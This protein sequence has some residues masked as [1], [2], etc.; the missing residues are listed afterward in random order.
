MGHF[1]RWREYRRRIAVFLWAGML[2]FTGVLAGGCGAEDGAKML[3][4]TGI[5]SW[6]ETLPEK[7]EEQKQLQETAELLEIERV[8]QAFPESMEEGSAGGFIS[9]LG[10]R[11][12]ECYGLIGTPEWGTDS[13]M[14]EACRRID[15]LADYN[16]R[17]SDG[18]R[19]AGV[20]ADIEPYLLSRWDTQPRQVMEEFCGNMKEIYL[21]A[22]TR[23]L[24]LTLCIPYW[25]DEDYPEFLEALVRDCCDEIAVMNYYVGKE[26]SHME[27]ELKLCRQYGKPIICISEFQPPGD[28]DLTNDNTYYNRGLAAAEKTWR[29][30]QKDSG[31]GKLTFAYH[32]LEPVRELVL[33]R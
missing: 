24:S 23:G 29:L 5:F 27:T 10:L 26:R 33:S 4:G 6:S 28:H 12:I 3:S 21:H 18:R 1:I 2:V 7:K 31:Y 25:Y 15:E 14:G 30:I 22:K 8:F 19:L 32:Y 20:V 17:V 9:D 13:G 16:G 11:G